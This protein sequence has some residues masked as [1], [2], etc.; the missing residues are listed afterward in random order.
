MLRQFPATHLKLVRSS[1]RLIRSKHTLPDLPYDYGALEPVISAEILQ[2]H[3][4]KHHATYVNNLNIAEEKL[5]EAMA[6]KDTVAAVSIMSALKFNA[7][8]HLNHSIYWTNLGPNCGGE[9]SGEFQLLNAVF[10]NFCHWFS[11]DL[12]KAIKTDFGSYANFKSLLTNASITVQG[13]GW[14]WL[15]Y[16]PTFNRLEMAVTQNQDLLQPTTGLIPLLTIDV[17]EHAYYLKYKNLRADY[18][19]S[20]WD[21]VNWKN[22]AERYANA[23]KK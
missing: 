6:K 3:H 23:V 16:N 17:W 14:G 15:G 10:L 9:P 18:V 12:A 19:K 20:I 13:S 22:V 21:I 5:H 8:G 7:G 2:V 11:G 4:Q 1:V